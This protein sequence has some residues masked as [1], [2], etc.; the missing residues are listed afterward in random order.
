MGAGGGVCASSRR[1]DSSP[2]P[3]LAAAL[4]QRVHFHFAEHTLSREVQAGVERSAARRS[5]AIAIVLRTLSAKDETACS[6]SPARSKVSTSRS[7][8]TFANSGK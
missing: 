5:V 3:S 1:R 2:T 4:G 8:D 7:E 6:F